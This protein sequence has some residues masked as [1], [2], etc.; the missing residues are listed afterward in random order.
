[1]YHQNIHNFIHPSLEFNQI[2]QEA[3]IYLGTC[4]KS[5]KKFQE[6][7]FDCFNFVCE[8]FV[9]LNAFVPDRT[10]TLA[11]LFYFAKKENIIHRCVNEGNLFRALQNKEMYAG[12]FLLQKE[13]VT[14]HEMHFH[15]GFMF[16]KQDGLVIIHNHDTSFMPEWMS[17]RSEKGVIMHILKKP[18]IGEFVTCWNKNHLSKNN[19]RWQYSLW[20]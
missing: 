8:V 11:D 4:Y 3:K 10:T 5:R 7:S 13:E 20:C 15:T 14:H 18:E 1:M 6:A 16:L 9:G 12:L 2:L 19:V 17:N